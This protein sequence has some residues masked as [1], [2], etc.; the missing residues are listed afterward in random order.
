[1]ISWRTLYG[2]LSVS[3]GDWFQDLLW[4]TKI[5]RWPCPFYNMVWYLHIPV[6]PHRL[7][8]GMSTRHSS[9]FS[10]VFCVWLQCVANFR[11]LDLFGIF[12]FLNIFD[13]APSPGTAVSSGLH[14]RHPPAVS[15]PSSYLHPFRC[16]DV[17]LSDMFVYCAGIFW[18]LSG[19]GHG[20]SILISK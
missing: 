8:Q 4:I 9:G 1:M 3:V 16:F 5:C 20:L 12:F 2:H 6:P 13:S 14:P 7:R 19:L 10:I 18:R 17:D 11:F 15:F